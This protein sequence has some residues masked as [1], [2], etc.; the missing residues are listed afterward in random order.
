M[1]IDL[2]FGW[3][4]EIR[5]HYG[6]NQQSHS[7]LFLG[8]LIRQFD[9]GTA[10]PWLAHQRDSPSLAK[11]M[12]VY[13]IPQDQLPAP[14]ASPLSFSSLSGVRKVW[15]RL[16]DLEIAPWNLC[17]ARR[18]SGM[19]DTVLLCSLTHKVLFNTRNDAGITVWVFPCLGWCS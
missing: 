4:H 15:D 7:N 13:L 11:V 9:A 8:N 3:L 10:A 14:R 6:E 2:N 5:C 18:G 19:T 12:A 16:W 1:Q 17:S